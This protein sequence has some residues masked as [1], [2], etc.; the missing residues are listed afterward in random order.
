M[1][2]FNKLDLIDKYKIP[3]QSKEKQYSS[4]VHMKYF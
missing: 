4:P 2:Q 3:S 1:S